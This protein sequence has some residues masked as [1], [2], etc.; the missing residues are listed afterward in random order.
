MHSIFAIFVSARKNYHFSNV[1]QQQHLLEIRFFALI[2]FTDSNLDFFVLAINRVHG[3]HFDAL[4]SRRIK[5]NS[6]R[7]DKILFAY[8]F[9]WENHFCFEIC[10]QIALALKLL[11]YKT[12]DM[13]RTAR[14]DS[15]ITIFKCGICKTIVNS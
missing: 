15:S 12:P 1:R 3:L 10:N 6:C 14:I 5:L 8:C 9:C 2:H 7:I 4:L 11:I 13:K